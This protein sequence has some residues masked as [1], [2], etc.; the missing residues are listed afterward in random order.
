MRS[1]R[2]SLNRENRRV[3][4]KGVSGVSLASSC[5]NSLFFYGALEAL[6]TE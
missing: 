2:V 4:R 1:K 3:V 5:V 6:V